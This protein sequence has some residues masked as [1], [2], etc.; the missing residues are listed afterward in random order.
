MEEETKN[1]FFA[2][3]HRSLTDN[4]NHIS[5]DLLRAK[6]FFLA[7][8]AAMGTAYMK[9]CDT[10]NNGIKTWGFLIIC[11]IGNMIFWFISEYTLSHA[12]LFRFIQSRLA[13]IEKLFGSPGNIKDP[14]ETRTFIKDDRLEIDYIIPDQFVPIY[15][16][17]TWLIIINS[18]TIFF[19]QD[20]YAHSKCS[21]HLWAY[22]AISVPF[23]GKLWTYYGYKL[24]KFIDEN[25]DFKIVSGKNEHYFKFP[26][27][28]SFILFFLSITVYLVFSLWLKKFEF[29][30]NTLIFLGLIGYFWPVPIGIVIHFFRTFLRL[31]GCLRKIGIFSPKV[32]KENSNYRVRL[33][34]Y[35]RIFPVLYNIT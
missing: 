24:D 25:C 5:G 19:L 6:W 10:Y 26:S 3:Y 12:F 1:K 8:I 2:D 14:T 4:L 34:R 33:P 15:W 11:L 27:G 29:D 35:L 13:K 22:V 28:P 32:I 30:L 17:S 18:I 9:I 16:A 31:D 7:S 21:L 20:F 23:I